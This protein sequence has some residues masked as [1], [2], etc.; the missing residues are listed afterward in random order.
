[1]KRSERNAT[2][3]VA[4]TSVNPVPGKI[5]PGGPLPLSP[6]FLNIVSDR[7]IHFLSL[8]IELEATLLRVL[9]RFI[10]GKRNVIHH[11]DH[12]SRLSM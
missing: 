5:T 2:Q 6:A 10:F 9:K 12:N 11:Y 1:M 4:I 3:I 7:V 8:G